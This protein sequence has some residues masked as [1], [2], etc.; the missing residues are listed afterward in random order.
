MPTV[1]WTKDKLERFRKAYV[2]AKDGGNDAIFKFEGYEFVVGYAKYLIEYL[3]GRF[4]NPAAAG[5]NHN[6]N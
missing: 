6:Y 5:F 3:D 2:A 4:R 1:N